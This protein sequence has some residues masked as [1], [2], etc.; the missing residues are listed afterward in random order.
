VQFFLSN[1][2]LAQLPQDVL[3]GICVNLGTKDLVALRET[4]VSIRDAVDTNSSLWQAL[5]HRKFPLERLN[6]SP[7]D[8][9]TT[10]L[11]VHRECQQLCLR[12]PSSRQRVLS[13]SGAVATVKL[14]NDEQQRIILSTQHDMLD[15]SWMSPT[16][17]LGQRWPG[18]GVELHGHS[19]RVTCAAVQL[20]EGGKVGCVSGSR[21]RTLR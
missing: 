3:S 5:V 19:G 14:L 8:W 9:R 2:A 1:M 10:F 11:E 15:L 20:L 13:G 16:L 18:T 12:H 7:T 17:H 21:D 4:S 6:W